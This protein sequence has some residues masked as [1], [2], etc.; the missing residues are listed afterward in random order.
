MKNKIFLC[1]CVLLCTVWAACNDDWDDD[2][3]TARIHVTVKDN[4]THIKGE[5]VYMF[6]S[7]HAPETSFF[8]PLFADANAVTDSYGETT[9]DVDFRTDE[10]L[11]YFGIFEGDLCIRHISVSVADGETISV[12]LNLGR[13]QYGY[14]QLKSIV[15]QTL[16]TVHGVNYTGDAN[17][18][19]FITLQLPRN[20]EKWFYA[21]SSSASQNVTP[22]LKLYDGLS[23]FV[24]E[25]EGIVSD[26]LTSFYVP[27]GNADCNIF[28]IK[29]NPNLDI[30]LDKS[31]SY[32]YFTEA[33][34]MNVNSG[35]VDVNISAN[36]GAT[37][38]LGIENPAPDNDIYIT[39]EVCALVW[40][41]N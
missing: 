35:L 29:D 12:E 32:E 18:R 9:F 19:S 34:R 17:N 30:F 11:F 24:N 20:T 14:Y 13:S 8:K 1:I 40:M 21:V 26:V 33:S 41:E 2:K 7:N 5:K 37:W 23:R 39:I 3:R 10:G 4:A 22:T 28:F 36:D 25:Q 38:Y 6:K 15:S 31:G 27:A 16:M